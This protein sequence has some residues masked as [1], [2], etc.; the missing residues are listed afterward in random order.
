MSNTL[1]R[2]GHRFIDAA[3]VGASFFL[4]HPGG[5]G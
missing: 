4:A 3:I 1:E 5:H 2:V